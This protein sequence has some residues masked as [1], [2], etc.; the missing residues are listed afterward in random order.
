[1][2]GSHLGVFSRGFYNDAASVYFGVYSNNVVV[3]QTRLFEV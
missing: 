2:F 1:M 3:Y